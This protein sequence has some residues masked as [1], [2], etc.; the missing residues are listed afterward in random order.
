MEGSGRRAW[1]CG[2]E[3]GGG[4]EKHEDSKGSPDRLR[5]NLDVIFKE[6]STG[7]VIIPECD[8]CVWGGVL[9]GGW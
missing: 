7:D 9:G 6:A 5:H 2:E 4:G 3:R 1:R 8:S